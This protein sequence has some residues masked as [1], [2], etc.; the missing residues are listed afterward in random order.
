ML[1]VVYVYA[2]VCQWQLLRL[3]EHLTLVDE[4]VTILCRLLRSS[5]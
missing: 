5:L 1:I 2:K 4:P 3:S